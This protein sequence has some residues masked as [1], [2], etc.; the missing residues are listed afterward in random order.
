MMAV[1]PSPKMRC[2]SMSFSPYYVRMHN[3]ITRPIQDEAELRQIEQME[4]PEY[5]AVTPN[6]DQMIGRWQTNPHAFLGLF[7]EEDG[8]QRLIGHI[9]IHPIAAEVLDRFRGGL[10]GYEEIWPL[11]L[12]QVQRD[13]CSLWYIGSMVIDKAFRKP[14]QNN[15]IGLLLAHALNAWSE[16]GTL[17][18]PISIYTTGLKPE[19]RAMLRRFGFQLEVEG[20]LLVNQAPLFALHAASKN[21]LFAPFLRRGLTTRW[22]G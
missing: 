13:G 21:D 10:A 17:R 4:S 3:F 8:G 9:R 22:G 2:L 6:I 12:A 5:Q 11:P 19:S 15:P 7:Q 14:T 20:A 16:S 18:Y 1:S